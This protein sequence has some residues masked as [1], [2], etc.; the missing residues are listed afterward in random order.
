MNLGSHLKELRNKHDTLS[1][2]IEQAQRSPAFEDIQITALKRQK[3]K[4]KEEIERLSLS[5]NA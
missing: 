1:Q 4:I 3:L 2:E 5:T